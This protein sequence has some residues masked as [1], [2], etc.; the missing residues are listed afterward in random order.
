MPTSP[1]LV[2]VVDDDAAV[3]KSL[4]FSLEL[5]GLTVRLYEDGD[6]LLR[7]G[8]LPDKGCLVVDY[9]MPAMN[10]LDVVKSLRRRHVEL[11]AILITAKATSEMRQRAEGAG[12]HTILEKPLEDSALLDNIRSVLNA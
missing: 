4:K 7:E 1:G 12:V 2:L 11:P 5:E 9:Y 10:G 8:R 6:A 3:R